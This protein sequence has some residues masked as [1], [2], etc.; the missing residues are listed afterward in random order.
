MKPLSDFYYVSG[1]ELNFRRYLPFSS[2][3]Q[4]S[5]VGANIIPI[6]QTGKWEVTAALSKL[7]EVTQVL[8]GQAGI[9]IQS[10]S[11]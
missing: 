4:T 7:P 6:L 1:T 10:L 3:E 2:S 8:S 9:G 11:S 5:E